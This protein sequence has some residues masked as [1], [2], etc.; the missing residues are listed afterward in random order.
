MYTGLCLTVRIMLLHIE[1][2]RGFSLS[3]SLDIETTR[4]LL[5]RVLVRS[6]WPISRLPCSRNSLLDIA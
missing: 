4:D 5:T 1:H 6:R 3:G 2:D